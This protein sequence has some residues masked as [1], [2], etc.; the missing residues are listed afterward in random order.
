MI[1]SFHLLHE[2][3]MRKIRPGPSNP[4]KDP[5]TGLEMWTIEELIANGNGHRFVDNPWV[6][7]SALVAPENLAPFTSPFTNDG[8]RIHWPERKPGVAVVGA[9]MSG[10]LTAYQLLIAGF[11]VYLYEVTPLPPKDPMAPENHGAGRIKPTLVHTPDPSGE[12]AAELGAMRFP[13]TS[14]LFWHYLRLF[15]VASAGELFAEFPNVSKVPTLFTGDMSLSGVWANG[16]L[17]LPSDYAKLD[18]RHRKAFLEWSAPAGGGF[19]ALSTQD[20]RE[21]LANS[22][23]PAAQGKIEW[24]WKYARANL[25]GITYRQFLVQQKFSDDDIR[26]IGYMGIGTGGF[27]P[28]FSVSAQDIFRLVLWGYSAEFAVPDLKQLPAKMLGIMRDHFSSNLLTRYRCSVKKIGYSVSTSSFYVKAHDET[29]QLDFVNQFSF[30]VL[31]MTHVAAQQ[32]LSDGAG[33]DWGN[34]P[35][36]VIPEDTV[37]PFYDTKKGSPTAPSN[38][39]TELE[40]QQ[41]MSAVKVFQTI[42]GPGVEDFLLTKFVSLL[43][44]PP[45]SVTYDNEVRALYGT[46]LPN[47]RS[48]AMGVTYLLPLRTSKGGE[49]VPFAKQTYVNSLQYSWGEDARTFYKTILAPD[50]DAHKSLEDTGM[51]QGLET[52]ADSI[53]GRVGENMYYR[54]ANAGKEVQGD[55]KWGFARYFQPYRDFPPKP[56]EGFLSIVAWDQVPYIRTGFKLDAPGV[57]SYLVS[58]YA[59]VTSQ[60]KSIDSTVWDAYNSDGTTRVHPSVKNLFFAGDSFSHYGGWV[61]GAFQS[62]LATSAAIIRQATVNAFGDSWKDKVNYPAIEALVDDTPPIPS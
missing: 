7:Y 53:S 3:I 2:P 56:D 43:P 19:P 60:N 27:A 46:Y 61:E 25:Y 41:G 8:E 54:L 11:Q 48:F 5:E 44:P 17:P 18:E 32:L 52:T 21:L 15:G 4:P 59:T 51:F 39:R 23:D 49:P 62:A 58:A 42:A 36:V 26:K 13:S 14:I 45:W 29:Q 10:L 40:K 1:P 34:D 12:S 6:D 30:V 35:T 33:R 38:I 9:G 24:Y 28:L 31:A 47:S 57:G 50:P 22:S 20:I 55:L 16:K 37:C